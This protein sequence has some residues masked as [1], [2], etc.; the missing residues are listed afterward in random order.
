[1]ALQRGHDAAGHDGIGNDAVILKA[2]MEADREQ[3]IGGLGLTIGLP[4]LIGTGAIVGVV[5]IDRRHAM[6]D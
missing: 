3:A 2:L 1:M 4:L 5:K 6:G